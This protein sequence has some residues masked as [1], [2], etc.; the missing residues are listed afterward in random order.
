MNYSRRRKQGHWQH[1]ARPYELVGASFSFY[2][3][4]E[5]RRLSVKEITCTSAF[6]ALNRPLEG[7]L[8]DPRLGPTDRKFRCLT[9]GMSSG[10][11]PGHMGH[12][13]LA[14]P[15]YHPLLFTTM[16]RI[17]KAKCT[18]CH[19]LRASKTQVKQFAMKLA[20]AREGLITECLEFD[21]KIGALRRRVAMHNKKTPSRSSSSAGGAGSAWGDAERS[22]AQAQKAEERFYAEM[23]ELVR[24]RR[25]Q[26]VRNDAEGGAHRLAGYDPNAKSLHNET[27]INELIDQFLKSMPAACA[28]C[29]G[30]S[31]K[32]RQDG[33]LKIFRNKLTEND[34]QSNRM[35]GLYTPS[36][37]STSFSA[38][39]GDSDGEEDADENEEENLGNGGEAYNKDLSEA[40]SKSTY[41]HALEV[42]EELRQLW[43]KECDILRLIWRQKDWVS[44][45]VEQKESTSLTAMTLSH[46]RSAAA[47]S[48]SLSPALLSLKG[49][50]VIRRTRSLSFQN[51]SLKRLRSQPPSEK[52][53]ALRRIRHIADISS[54]SFFIQVLPVAPSR[55]RP[56]QEMGGMIMEHPQNVMLRAILVANEKLKDATEE[57]NNAAL[58][59][60]P[61][62]KRAFANQALQT[63]LN[64]WI[65][66][67]DA[68]NSLIDGTRSRRHRGVVGVKQ[69]L[70]KKEGLF[71]RNMMG[72]RVNFAARSV[73]SP[74]PYIKTSEVGVPLRFAVKLT[75]PEPV[76]LLN[77]SEMRKLVENGP[78]THPGANWLIDEFGR[79]QDFTHMSDAA[80]IALSKTLLKAPPNA[81]PGARKLVGRHLRNGDVL[82][83][84]RQPTLHKPSIMAHVARILR[85]PAMQTIRL[86]YANCNTYNADFDG[87]EINLH[88]PQNELA[89]AEAMHIVATSH[90]YLVPTDGSPLRGLIQDHVDC[91]VLLTR[92]GA[93]LSQ[94]EYTQLVYVACHTFAEEK[95]LRLILL[96][97]AV[98]YR[99]GGKNGKGIVR[100]WTGKQLISTIL[101]NLLH[102]EPWTSSGP[103]DE[104][105]TNGEQKQSLSNGSNGHSGRLQD[106]LT[107]RIGAGGEIQS[108]EKLSRRP[109]F[110]LDGK[111]KLDG[112]LWDVGATGKEEGRVIFRDSEL[113]QGI[114][115][116]NQFG[117]ASFGFVHSIYELYGPTFADEILSS[118]GR[119]FTFYIQWIHGFTCGIGDMILQQDAEDDRK[120]IL[121]EVSVTGSEV[122]REFIMEKM[123]VKEEKD[124]TPPNISPEGLASSILGESQEEK[125]GAISEEERKHGSTH[126]REYLGSFLHRE[127][128]PGAAA[129]D[130]VVK[131]KLMEGASSVN[132][133][134]LPSGLV[135]TFPR[136]CMLVMTNSGAKGSRV[137]HSMISCCLGQQELE[138]R[139]VPTM[140]S[141]KTLPSFPPNSLLPRAGG[142]IADRFLTG[143]RP[144]EY[145][146]HCMS[147][148]EGLVD[149]AVK[150]SRS[151][152]LQR[153]LI[154]HMENLVVQYDHTVR[155]SDCG[156]VVQF[157][158][159]GDGIDTTC[160]KFL[161]GKK[162]QLDFIKANREPYSAL[163]EL[164]KLGR[165][166]IDES[167]ARRSH[168]RLE[169]LKDQNQDEQKKKH[170]GEDVVV[171]VNDV[172]AIPLIDLDLSCD[173]SEFSF[174]DKK[175]KY[176]G[177][178]RE[179]LVVI[180]R[181]WSSEDLAISEHVFGTVVKVRTNGDGEDP[182]R[183][184]GTT[185][186]VKVD[187]KEMKLERFENS[188]DDVH[189]S[190]RRLLKGYFTDK[191][192]YTKLVFRRI[193][194]A[195]KCTGVRF[196]SLKK[197]NKS[198]PKSKHNKK[199]SKRGDIFWTASVQDSVQLVRKDLL[200]DPLQST[201]GIN[202]RGDTIGGIS[203]EALD[204]YHH[205]DD[206]SK[207]GGRME[208]E[209]LVWMKALLSMAVPGEPVGVLAA[210]S[211]GEPSTQMTLN[212]FHLAGHGGANVTLGIPRLRELLMTASKKPATPSMRL[213]ISLLKSGS[214]SSGETPMNN[215]TDQR[216]ADL[217]KKL[218]EI[219]LHDLLCGNRGIIQEERLFADTDTSEIFRDYRIT[220]RI[221]P[222]QSIKEELG[223]SFAQILRTVGA[224]VL[225]KLIKEFKDV[226]GVSVE[227]P[228]TLRTTEEVTTD[229]AFNDTAQSNM[230]V[231]D[232]D[233]ES[234]EDEEMGEFAAK[235]ELVSYDDD[236][237]AETEDSSTTVSKKKN[238]KKKE[239][240]EKKKKK[241]KL[242]DSEEEDSSDDSDDAKDNSD[243]EED[244]NM[245]EEEEEEED[246]YHGMD[247]EMNG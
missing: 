2:T 6:D 75:Y 163:Y 119:V 152:Y 146:F 68:V 112:A 42:Q 134:C 52:E 23:E 49:Q 188:Q 173:E 149:T 217:V 99:D 231:D 102:N 144:Q 106:V 181:D 124:D 207:K 78:H 234:L 162:G 10:E 27:L 34:R 135:K 219:R 178:A 94:D 89:R 205:A 161:S 28:N 107:M 212:T 245:E 236:D 193:P 80:R 79:V 154:K 65:E 76:N 183:E 239:R 88:F 36:Y 157:L 240:K 238:K 201:F 141:G 126:L 222:L 43:M 103:L 25:R 98:Q 70:E 138:G 90:Q 233:A 184:V 209:I 122:Q 40:H 195:V 189:P 95:G 186:D 206:E 18:F 41:V 216:A 77:E 67:Q 60:T 96:P 167:T 11:C 116:K 57:R 182:A 237:D 224:K 72:K 185:V 84:N 86:H 227:A 244:M 71:R 32:Y 213:P 211:V 218:N 92:R 177:T 160:N 45:E 37:A 35:K 129:L 111:S 232:S 174:F 51:W 64:T 202:G 121:S 229:E 104:I 156:A 118:L 230:E 55:F 151:G 109:G 176:K 242:E 21:R 128:V 165:K 114:L 117:H 158:Y 54:K 137:N 12:I 24:A 56:C 136:N 192:K 155:D 208:M 198:S 33:V 130:N 171:E 16:L 115:D 14:V 235:K 82:L 247:V 131:A 3:A 148:R 48:A 31:P 204:K 61:Q 147:G 53:K 62:E 220:L 133:R 39:L 197:G 153:C 50:R 9:C 196:G 179:K 13:E 19:S 190:L 47:H 140:V 166:G 199:T 59:K 108:L 15:C 81:P 63:K 69:I 85:N 150:T 221:L 46:R 123:N 187:L 200:P 127:G 74:D 26:R 214:T 7:G 159:G 44:G 83:A 194:L 105:T 223:V 125:E 101:K 120:R 4:E 93:F 100:L 210:Q 139:R 143:I 215:A 169:K 225:P 66:L 132:M 87:D 91:G 168:R 246:P 241:K 97:P 145:Y 73:I 203:E 29:G 38:S 175:K 228:E 180:K 5:I 164:E 142:F 30:I 8:Y 22:L 20:L 226:I 17:L 110:S 170:G 113:L 243:V 172:V 191:K 1:G 58:A